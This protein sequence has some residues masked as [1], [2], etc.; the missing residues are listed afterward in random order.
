MAVPSIIYLLAK[1]RNVEPKFYGA[2]EFQLAEVEALRETGG[3]Y[4]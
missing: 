1:V 4:C 3:L 2:M